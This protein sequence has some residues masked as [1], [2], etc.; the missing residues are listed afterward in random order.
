MQ[1]RC[2]QCGSVLPELAPGYVIVTCRKCGTTRAVRPGDPS[3]GS[4]PA[5]LVLAP[6]GFMVRTENGGL[7]LGWRVFSVEPLLGAVAVP[8]GFGLAFLR[9]PDA[10]EQIGSLG[11]G[12]IAAG[13]LVLFYLAI[14]SLV[15]IRWLEVRG[16]QLVLGSGP[17]PMPRSSLADVRTL[18]SISVKAFIIRR[19]KGWVTG[20]RYVVNAK[21]DSGRVLR[22]G[23]EFENE[24]EASFIAEALRTYLGLKEDTGASL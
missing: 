24:S 8:L 4:E 17:L 20:T 3:G 9:H 15:N 14:A 2:E 12:A 19:Q 22:I 13:A 6:P 10:L 1:P 18:R 16:H 5:A 23:N 11:Q 21:D 7:R